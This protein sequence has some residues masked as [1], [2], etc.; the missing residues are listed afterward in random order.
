MPSLIELSNIEKVYRDSLNTVS[1]LKSVSLSIN[2]G[3]FVALVGASGSGKTT[4]LNILGC[5]D[6]PSAGHFFVKGREL[7]HSDD[8]R[9]SQFRNQDVGF[10]F[11]QFNLIP[12]LS[13]QLNVELA[14]TYQGM[15]KK[16]RRDRSYQMLSDVGLQHRYHHRPSELSGGERQ[17]VAI[18]RAL[19]TQ[20]QLLLADEPTG[21]LDSETTKSIMSLL[22]HI[23]SQGKTIVMVTHDKDIS[24]YAHREIVMK[25]GKLVHGE[26]R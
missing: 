2:V 22:R 14:L 11:Q 6:Q 4:L 12:H 20:P 10:I 23:N 26:S 18:A 7:T 1:V 24:R 9:R 8:A 19:V 13:A 15:S 25:D 3:E 16:E 21:N 5:L 17:R